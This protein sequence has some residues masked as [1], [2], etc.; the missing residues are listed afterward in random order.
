MKKVLV[1][2]GAGYIGSVLVGALL[3]NGWQVRVFDNLSFGGESLLAYWHDPMFSFTKGDITSSGDVEG[4]SLILSLMRWC[5]WRPLSGTLLALP[6][7]IW[8]AKLIGKLHGIFLRKSNLL[9]APGL[10]FHRRAAITGKWPMARNMW[11][12]I[13]PGPGISIRRDQG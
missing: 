7:L 3:R 11:M 8:P 1:T 2:G 12:K 9:D 13:L 4:C 6:R 10:F 5:I